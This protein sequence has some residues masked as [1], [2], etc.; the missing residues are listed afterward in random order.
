VTFALGPEDLPAA[1][2]AISVGGGQ[3]VGNTPHVKGT[4]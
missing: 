3:P 4:L 1:E 2:V